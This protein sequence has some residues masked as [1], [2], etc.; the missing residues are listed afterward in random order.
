MITIGLSRASEEG[1]YQLYIKWLKSIDQS[2]EYI[3]FYG[4]DLK[5]WIIALDL[6]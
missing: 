2:F 1:K 4:M 6:C 5:H 3:N